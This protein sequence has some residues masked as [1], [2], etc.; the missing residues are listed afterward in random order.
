MAGAQI[1]TVS[2]GAEKAKLLLAGAL[3]IGGLAAYYLL[4]SQGSLIQ[5]V[6]LLAGVVLGVV[7]FFVSEPGRRLWA[8][9]RDSWREM[10]KVVWPTRKETMQTTA[11]VF[12]FAVA[13]ALFLWMVDKVLG[14]VLYDLILGWRG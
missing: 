5:W 3:V 9:G 8:F 6:G 1:Q 12:A 13:I 10:Y 14:W 4:A 7:T 11:F 2:S